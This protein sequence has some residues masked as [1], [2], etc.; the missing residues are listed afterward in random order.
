MFYNSCVRPTTHSFW[1]NARIFG[2]SLSL[3]A[4]RVVRGCVR[5]KTCAS[6]WNDTRNLSWV[7]L[8]FI[9]NEGIVVSSASMINP[10][11][12]THMIVLLN[13]TV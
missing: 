4:H 3:S 10:A 7:L 9:K 11:Y 6:R 5:A 12:V 13:G 8:S 1:E 2:A